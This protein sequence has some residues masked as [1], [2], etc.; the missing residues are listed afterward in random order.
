[1]GDHAWE[2]P[3]ED[4]GCPMT[5]WFL[6]AVDGWNSKTTS[7]DQRIN[8]LTCWDEASGSSESKAK[9]CAESVSLDFAA[10]SACQSGAK[11]DEL[12][13]AAAKYFEGRFPDHAHSGIFGVPHLFLNG[14]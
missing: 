8:F 7:Q 14:E 11:G 12:Q 3:D 2:C 6:C 1:M 9:A 5:R 13:V 10:I 4:P